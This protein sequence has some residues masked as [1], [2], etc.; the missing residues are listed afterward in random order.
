ME[1][2]KIKKPSRKI[3]I[4]GHKRRVLRKLD[5]YRDIVRQYLAPNFKPAPEIAEQTINPKTGKPYN[6][7]T[8]YRIINKFANGEFEL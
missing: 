7:V 1:T 4:R 8:I 5:L 3:L 6:A 2:Q